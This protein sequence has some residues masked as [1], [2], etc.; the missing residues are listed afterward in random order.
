[1]KNKFASK[2]KII[3]LSLLVFAMLLL[4]HDDGAD[5]KYWIAVAISTVSLV[6]IN[7]EYFLLY[8]KTKNIE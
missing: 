4:M 8:K 1:M 3:A 2:L 5:Y 7:Y 6:L